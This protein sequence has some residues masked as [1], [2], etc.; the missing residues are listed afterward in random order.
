M[1]RGQSAGEAADAARRELGNV[2]LVK[3]VTREQWGWS[4]VYAKSKG[5]CREPMPH[6]RVLVETASRQAA[7]TGRRRGS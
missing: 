3:E 2:G 6:M 1:A 5:A 7:M 4:S